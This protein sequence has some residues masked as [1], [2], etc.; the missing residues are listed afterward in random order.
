MRPVLGG[1]VGSDVGACVAGSVG[2]DELAGE[3]GQ[4]E[5]SGAQQADRPA[6]SGTSVGGGNREGTG[7]ARKQKVEQASLGGRINATH[8]KI[9]KTAGTKPRMISDAIRDDLLDAIYHF[10]SKV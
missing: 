10:L 4:L 3:N 7:G 5:K 8:R 1:V 9:S 2:T 6:I